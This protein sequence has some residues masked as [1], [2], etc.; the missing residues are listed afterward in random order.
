M[1]TER[2]AHFVC[3]PDR[4]PSDVE[5]AAKVA[6]MDTL[7]CALGGFPEQAA[8]LARD[9]VA[10]VGARAVSTVWGAN[11]SS[12]PSEAAFANA[13]AA[14]VLDFDDTLATLR[15]HA[16]ATTLPVALAIGEQVGAS[17]KEVLLAYAVG[18][19]TAGKLGRIFGNG[20]YLRG[21][22][23]TATVGIFAATAVAAFMHHDN[24]QTLRNAWGIAAAQCG[25]V[26][27]NFGTMSKSFQ[28]GHAV[29]S[30]IIAE[31]LARR[32]FTANDTMFDGDNSFQRLYGSSVD[33]GAEFLEA[34]GNP[35][36]LMQPGMNYKRWPCCYCSHRA[37]GGLLEL[38]AEHRIE[39]HEIEQVRV[40]FPPG[41]D[42][43]LVYDNPWTG[44]EGKFSAQY[45]VASLLLD[46]KLD[47][48][49]FTDEAV[50]RAAVRA[51]MKKI[52]R[53]RVEDTQ[54]Y[55]GTVGYTDVTITARGS[56]FS[57]RIDKGPGSRLWPM[58]MQEHQEKF[59]SCARV[60]MSECEAKHLLDVVLAFEAL[61]DVRLFTALTV[62][63]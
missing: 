32:G 46:G 43:P 35:W 14:H 1:L 37:L 21:W 60:R 20:H 13:I 56:E 2:L 18:I 47:L 23:N 51:M 24:E 30:A 5:A 40:G 36:E 28:V 54:V 12:A 53:Y 6:L 38:I 19:E 48:Q 63:Q 10:D 26:L 22:H 11:L 33:D 4:L 8:R 44:L 57:R 58:S 34:L 41:S 49:S 52:E 15:G 61:G 39:V 31:D 45:P 50:Q 25:G 17:G 62:P 42:E 16:S 29:R 9:H 55:S 7:A 3:Q 27:R 59:F